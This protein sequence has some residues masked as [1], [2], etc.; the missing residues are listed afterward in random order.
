MLD[1]SLRG[2]NHRFW[3]YLG[4]LGQNAKFVYLSRYLIG[5]NNTKLGSH[6]TRM[7]FYC[8]CD[9]NP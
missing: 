9:P 7:S 2:E 3:S 8:F 4:C 6:N 5:S 1:V